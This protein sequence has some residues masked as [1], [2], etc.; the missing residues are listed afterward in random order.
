LYLALKK[1]SPYLCLDLSVILTIEL[2]HDIWVGLLFSPTADAYLNPSTIT[3][4]SV[5]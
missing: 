1:P 2:R 4:V 5:S 3:E